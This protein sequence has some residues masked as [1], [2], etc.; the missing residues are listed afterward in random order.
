MPP[1]SAG[2]F[3]AIL[4]TSLT[5]LIRCVLIC[6]YDIDVASAAAQITGYRLANLS[7]GRVEITFQECI[8]GHEHAW[9]AVA[10]LQAVFLEESLLERVELSVLLESLDSQYLA[11]IG[12]D[13]ENCAR[14]DR[15]AVHD[16]S[17]GSTVTRIATDMCAGKPQVLPQEMN[18]QQS[19]LHF[20]RVLDSVDFHADSNFCHHLC[21]FLCA[22]DRPVERSCGQNTND[23]SFVFYRPA[24][25]F[26]RVRFSGS[27][28]GCL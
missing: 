4:Y 24:D 6:L 19:R 23:V 14:L 1:I 13:C 26:D 11:S 21:P 22:L 15:L 16:Y 18:Q 20:R 7:L 2:V 25:I 9:R 12:L 8:S 5:Q 27:Q 28:F 3:G 17:T 10:A